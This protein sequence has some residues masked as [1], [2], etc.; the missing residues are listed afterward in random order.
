MS[1]SRRLP[2]RDHEWID[3][4]EPVSFRFEGKTYRGYRG[5]VLSSALWAND[6]RMVGR[7]FKYHRPRG[8]YSLANHDVSAMV[9]D[10]R[11]TNLRG[12]VLPIEPGLDVQAVNTFGGLRRDL[13]RITEWFSA[14]LPVGFYYKAFHTPRWLFPFYE[15]QMR[16]VAGL[17]RIKPPS[18]PSASPKDYAHCDLLVVGTGPAGLAAAIAAAEQGVR[19]LAVEEQPHPGGSFNWQW[20]RD[21]Q[22]RE[23]RDNLLKRVQSLDHMQI[24]CG[25]QASGWYADHW[26]ALTDPQR[27]TKLRAKALVV[28]TGCFEQPAVFQN[29]DLPGVMLASAAQ[30]LIH[31]YAVQP[32]ERCV[33][34]AANR[35]AYRAALDL[36][37]ADVEISMLV[38]LRPN[39]EPTSLGQQVAKAGIPIRTGHT[40]YQALPASGKKRLKGAIIGPWNPPGIS[41]SKDGR[42]ETVVDCDGIAVSVGWMPAVGLLYQAGARFVH[43][44]GLGQFRPDSCPPSVFAAGRANGVYD[45]SDQIQDGHR[46]GL[47][48]AAFLGRF[49]GPVPDASTHSGPPPSHPYPIIPHEKKKN[50]VDFDEDLHLSDFVNA[51]QEGYD[52][53]ELIKRY[54]TVGM[55]P[56]QGKLANM[57]AVRILA[58]LNGKNINETGTTTSRPFHQPV[59]LGH[60]AGRRFH[61]LRRTPMHT[62]HEQADAHFIHVGEWLR[63][64]YYQV[65]DR[66][67]SDCILAEAHHVRQRVGLIDVGT[68]GKI[69]ISGQDA[70]DFLERI[71]TGR[72]AKQ[73]VGRV[74]YALACDESGVIIEDGIIAR[75]GDDHFYVTATSSGTAAFYRELQRWAIIWRMKV[76][77]DNATGQLAAMNLAGPD[78]RQVMEQVTDLDL[79]P[80]GF[81]YLGARQGIVAD[82]PAT[83]LRVGFVGEWGYEIHVP[84]SSG[85]HVWNELNAA[86]RSMEI[87]PFGVEAQRLLR[88]EKG[89]LIV[90]QDTD[91]LTTPHEANVSW[92]IGKNK[93]FFIGQR[94]LAVL[95]RR[96]PT[97]QL[98]GIQFD[99][100]VSEPLPDEC[101]LVIEDGQISGRVTSIAKRT[102]LARPIG[103]A[104]VRPDQAEPGRVI[105]I[106]VDGGRMI[107]ATVVKTPFYDPENE[108][109]GDTRSAFGEQAPR[110]S[111]ES[112]PPPRQRA[113]DRSTTKTMTPVHTVLDAMGARWGRI[114]EAPVATRFTRREI[115]ISAMRELALCDMSV[116]P[117]LGIKG[118]GSAA[119]LRAEGVDVPNETYATACLPD[120][121]LIACVAVDEFIMESGISTKSVM[122]LARRI[123]QDDG[124]AHAVQRQDATF[125]V[126]GSRACEALSQTCAINFDEASVDRLIL[127]RVAG[128]T[129]GLLPQRVPG[130]DVPLFRLWLDA[131]FAIF[132]WQNLAQIIEE[133][134]GRIIGSACY[135]G[136]IEQV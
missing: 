62:W 72:F 120:G 53:I 103:M 21:P 28:A 102:T 109:Q 81:P 100:D 18:G 94:S 122:S 92:A 7:S 69:Q 59:P 33:V 47:A 86:G 124:A 43:D 112:G 49:R 84:A 55:G 129:C 41:R 80:Q 29:N 70:V 1:T 91:A 114:G 105:R 38:D 121:G 52:S 3:R 31:Q 135:L 19:V 40:V 68:L 8:V 106:R 32:F 20:A 71:Y 78:A 90:G 57:N 48:A 95:S 133:I 82:V 4:R 65:K 67:R 14:F 118:P 51:H 11:R 127:T 22:A 56:T 111:D 119:W 85:M 2:P 131:T 35:D 132:L 128:V 75:L 13:Y 27:L 34:L 45:F 17:G 36:V 83:I 79:S 107:E 73:A 99:R 88:L 6:V 93:P 116:L 15:N 98:V 113:K 108:K 64:E 126:S 76:V 9:E 54:T 123:A 110:R 10:D 23:Q 63:P 96:A 77:L 42:A 5:D 37:E 44:E 66:R 89:H 50:F 16:K 87:R 117:K 30:R 58:R 125:L 46:T 104:F 39:G 25:T 74:R 115:E 12:D 136:A 60:L 134:G 130:E 26:I 97:R 24:R 61:P 101:N